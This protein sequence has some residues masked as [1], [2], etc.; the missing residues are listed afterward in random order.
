[1]ADSLV[2]DED[3]MCRAPELRCT[4]QLDDEGSSQTHKKPNPQWCPDGLSKSQKRRFQCLHQLEEHGEAERLVLNNKKV[5]SQIWR[6]KPKA[7]EEKDDKP[8]ANINTVVF[9]PKE[10]IAP[11]DS[12]VF[13]E[14][15]GMAQLTLEPRHDIFEKL[16]DEKRQ[17]LKA[18]FLN[19]FVNGKLVTKM[20]VDGGAAVNLMS[21][22]MLRK[23]GKSNEDLTQT[24]M[25]LVDFEGNVSPAQGTICVELTIGSKTLPTAFFVIK[26]RGSYN[27]LLVRDW[28]FNG[29]GTRRNLLDSGS[30]RA[31]GWTYDRVSCI[32]G[33]AWD[34]KYLKVFYFGLKPVQA[35]DSDDKT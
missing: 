27:L 19:G 14:K 1:M 20:L 6:P 34:T 3:I 22:T 12:D 4:L 28:R 13:D 30:Y 21:Y 26:G 7:D 9:L 17:H 25:M 16:E 8:Q 11:V 29:G 24:D 5:R 31:Q 15:L 23:N 10:F 33:K 35:A 2:P 32:F 18:L